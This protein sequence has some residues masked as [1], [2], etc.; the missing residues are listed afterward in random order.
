[1]LSLAWAQQPC[2]WCLWESMFNK[3]QR[4]TWWCEECSKRVWE[5]TAS[6]AAA[7]KEDEEE[8][9]QAQDQTFPCDWW[10]A[11]LWSRGICQ[12][13]FMLEQSNSVR[14]KKRSCYDWPQPPLPTA[15]HG[16]EEGRKGGRGE[17]VRLS[18]AEGSPPQCILAVRITGQ[19]SIE[20]LLRT[21]STFTVI[22]LNLYKCSKTWIK[23]HHKSGI[24]GFRSVPFLNSVHW[25]KNI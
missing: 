25:N 11:P 2:W 8:V 20:H 3:G 15:L 1:M 22:Y 14:R 10:R 4:T 23:M 12:G 16:S 21:D 13:V 17:E 18:L 24:T 19:H 9:L 6:A 7:A 5:T